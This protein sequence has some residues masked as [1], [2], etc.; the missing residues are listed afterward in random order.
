MNVVMTGV[1]RAGRGAGDR[2][3][4]AVL[5]RLAGRAAGARGKGHRGAARRPGRGGPRRLSAPRRPPR[6]RTMRSALRIVIAS[7]NPHKLR[8]L[9]GAA[10]SPLPRAA[11]RLGRAA[12]RRRAR[13]STENALIKARAAAAATGI[14]GARRRLRHR[15][16]GARR[17]ARACARRAT[18]ASDATDEQNLR[19]L[20]DEMRG[21]GGSRGRVRVRARARR[22]GRHGAASSRAA[23]RAACSS[24]PRGERRASA[25]TRCSCPTTSTA[26]SARW[27]SCRPAEKD[28]ISHRGRAVRAL[29]SGCPRGCD[30][31]PGR[32]AGESGRRARVL[33]TPLIAPGR[34]RGVDEVRRGAAVGRL[35]HG[36]DR[37][38][39]R[40]R[41]DHGLDR[42]HHRGGP[43]EHRPARLD[44]RLPVAAQGGRARRRG[45]HMYGH[46][47]VENLAAAIEG[48]LILVG[49]GV[50]VYEA[51]RRLVDRRRGREH[52]LR[53]RRDR[54]LGGRQ[55]RGVHLPVPAGARARLA[56]ARGR[57]G[58]P[59]RRR[60]DV[61]RGAASASC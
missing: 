61:A 1:G 57:R 4:R 34:R 45:A 29:S 21:R 3:G 11:A 2:R 59:A 24:S 42:D 6:S 16:R 43:L 8:E 17:R 52:R 46:A 9:A 18:P 58:A 33:N 49:A 27:P 22:A 23:A 54:D 14:P 44:R 41:R 5:A 12:R 56:R 40:R 35:E 48:M 30:R 20:L 32:R 7:R 51:S 28:A 38:E 10:G 36:P 60:R 15:G 47:K 53:H 39:G 13:P 26:T 25:T 19:K 50:I 55:P 37:A 31:E